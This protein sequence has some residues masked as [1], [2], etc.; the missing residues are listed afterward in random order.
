MTRSCEPLVS[1]IM[2]T[3][4]RRRFVPLAVD[5]FLNQTY[6]RKELLVLDDGES[7]EDLIPHGASIRYL[8]STKKRSH[9][10]KANLGCRLARGEIVC[11]WDDDDWS[12][13]TRIEEQVRGLVE[14]RS[15]VTGYHSLF[16]FD[17]RTG[18]AFEYRGPKG[19]AC[20]SSLC[21]VK[22]YWQDH[23]FLPLQVGSDNIFAAGAASEGQLWATADGT[24]MV[25]RM[26]ADNT[27]P[28]ILS[29]D[30]YREVALA[31]LPE[32]FAGSLR[33][34]PRSGSQP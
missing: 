17:E 34:R 5:C 12:A 7:V 11:H 13:P 30:H 18:R 3:F 20:G 15:S 14:S 8:R 25:F 27:S 6:R 32:G 31:C 24:Q 10:R 4:N 16:C 28:K 22:R 9:G 19:Y 33:T 29:P 2:P 1:A 23:R 26:H 21:Y